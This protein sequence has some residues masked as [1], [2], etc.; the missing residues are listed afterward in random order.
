[1]AGVASTNGKLPAKIIFSSSQ[2][3]Q[4]HRAKWGA[5]TDRT[6]PLFWI[7]RN[8]SLSGKENVGSSLVWVSRSVDW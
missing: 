1:M 3:Q 7:N 6:K 5:G 8:N 4:V 2:A